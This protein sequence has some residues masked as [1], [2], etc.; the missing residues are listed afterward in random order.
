MAFKDRI[1]EARKRNGLSQKDVADALNVSPQLISFWEKGKNS[2][3]EKAIYGLMDL[4]NI[5][6]NYLYQDEMKE[7]SKEQVT[8]EEMGL[9]YKYRQLREW[10]KELVQTTINALIDNQP[11]E[12]DPESYPIP[13]IEKR[14]YYGRPS[15]GAGNGALDLD[16]IIRIRDSRDARKAD[17]V[18]QVDGRSMEPEF[19]DGDFVLVKSQDDIEDGEIGIWCVDGEIYIKEKNGNTL[20][21]LNPEY[22]DVP[23][24]DFSDIRCYGKVIGKAEI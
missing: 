16:G 22:E 7:T 19:K 14:Y 23:L 1:K 12:M 21:S 15:A 11:Q 10:E 3:N 4:L 13:M 6:A 2:P 18:L 17:F 24:T 5:D 9:I 20:H 8:G